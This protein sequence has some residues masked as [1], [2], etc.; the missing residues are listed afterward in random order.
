M[1]KR[2]QRNSYSYYCTMRLGLSYL[3][4]C[5]VPWVAHS[6]SVDPSKVT[7]S[8][9]N[10]QQPPNDWVAESFQQPKSQSDHEHVVVGP[11]RALIYDTTLRGAKD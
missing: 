7:N 6:F 5:S 3:L 9:N 2:P 11:Q 8:N 10:Q 1:T 4:L